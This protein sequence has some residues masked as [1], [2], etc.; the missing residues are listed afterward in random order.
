MVFSETAKVKLPI[1]KVGINGEGIGYYRRKAVFV[2]FVLPGE[3]A[4]IKIIKEHPNYAEGSVIKISKQ[5]P[6]RIKPVCPHYEVCGGCSLQHVKYETGLDYKKQIVSD[7]F[8]KYFKNPSGA[9]IADTLKAPFVLNYRNRVQLPVAMVKG[10]LVAGLYKPNTNHLVPINSC[11]IHN[12]KLN[13]VVATTVRLANEFDIKAFDKNTRRGVLRT[14]A[15]RIGFNTSQMQLTLVVSNP[16]CIEKVKSLIAEV[17]K[18]H[19]DIVSTYIN[20]N[21]NTKTHEMYG[22]EWIHVSGR[23]EIVERLG[24]LKFSLLPR[25]FFQLNPKQ[26]EI[27][28]NL[29]LEKAE[30][31]GDETVVDAYCGTGTISLWLAKKA[32]KVLGVDSDKQSIT[33]ANYNAKLNNIK[34]V[35]FELG[36]AEY[37]I[38][39]WV[40]KGQ[41]PDVVVVDPARSG[42][43]DSFIDTLVSFPVNKIIYVSCNPSTLAKNLNKLKAIYDVKS[44]QPLDMFPQTAH[45]ETIT[46]L[47]KRQFN[48][49]GYKKKPQYRR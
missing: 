12:D 38:G 33:S 2:P 1:N 9:N 44:V 6:N 34:N 30:L 39:K 8:T 42:L 40:K 37:V 5:S 27:M 4:E 3:E 23:K 25:T 24:S 29:I 48:K 17:V 10:K 20:V 46:V 45:V 35:T 14:I 31:T 15:A 36:K 32:K 11:P 22:N 43:H 41:R 26:T 18:L 16:H 28:Y 13:K 19:P 7:S 47:E 21:K 49:K